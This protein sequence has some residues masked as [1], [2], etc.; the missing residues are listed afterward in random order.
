MAYD[1]PTSPDALFTKSS[2]VDAY[3][4]TVKKVI[5]RIAS[6]KELLYNKMNIFR[7]L[8]QHEEQ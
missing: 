4:E 6:T 7:F 3:A 1:T 2:R 5:D 8:R